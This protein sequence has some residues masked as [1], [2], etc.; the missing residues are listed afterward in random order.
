[1]FHKYI[2]VIS[3][4]HN[5]TNLSH[6]IIILI[7]FP[8]FFFSSQYAKRHLS[9]TS[10]KRYA[11][12]N[13]AI[14]LIGS[15]MRLPEAVEPTGRSESTPMVSTT[16]FTRDTPDSWCKPRTC[17]RTSTSLSE[18]IFLFWVICQKVYDAP[19]LPSTSA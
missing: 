19:M 3:L 10:R 13:C 1:M 12:G 16:C 18:V 6:F 11:A 15:H 7:L 14:I 4:N 17:F 2:F 5:Y 9:T 8:S